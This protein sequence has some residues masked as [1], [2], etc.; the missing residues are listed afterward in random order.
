MARNSIAIR[1]PVDEVGGVPDRGLG[2]P[3][4]KALEGLLGRRGPEIEACDPSDG[5]LIPCGFHGFAAAVH[6]AY[7]AHAPLSIAPDHVWL[8]IAQGLAAHVHLDPER[9]CRQLSRPGS[10]RTLD[11]RHDGLTR[12]APADEWAKV[13][14]GFTERLKSECPGLVDI[15][16]A[17]FSTTGRSDRL[18]SAIAAMDVF[19]PYFEYRVCTICG[20]PMITL[21]GTPDDWVAV[22]ERAERLRAFGLDWWLDALRPLLDQFVSASAGHVDRAWWRGFFKETGGSGGPYITGHIRALFPYLCFKERKVPRRI[23]RQDFRGNAPNPESLLTSD[24]L[25][26]G[27]SKVPFTW[28]HLDADIPMEV[29]A[30]FVG[31][32]DDPGAGGFRPEVGW[33]VRVS[34]R[35]SVTSV[36]SG[37]LLPA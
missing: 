2:I 28:R 34:E 8:V 29:V 19:E 26:A 30:G 7:S 37:S 14:D 35:S 10:R 32:S 21:E 15:L 22:R 12:H 13:W 3:A 23:V 1:F 31:I 6:L 33:A 17:R 18:A 20:I 24:V 11:V 27:L 4:H 16:T 9:W 5:R 36:R 25:P